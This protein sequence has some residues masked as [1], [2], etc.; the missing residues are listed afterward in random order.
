M[1][2]CV[3]AAG[4]GRAPAPE[5]DAPRASRYHIPEDGSCLPFRSLSPGLTFSSPP[6][7]LQHIVFT[8]AGV[9]TGMV[10]KSDVVAL[11][12]ARFPETGA[13]ETAPGWR[14]TMFE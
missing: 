4:S 13:L 8:Q 5:G 7:N 3:L 9:L 2:R 11:L 1:R 14:G 6:Q 12:T 10:T